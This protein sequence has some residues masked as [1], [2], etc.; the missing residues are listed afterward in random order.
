MADK[1]PARTYAPNK[2]YDQALKEAD[3][4]Y[5]ENNPEPPPSDT[6]PG[7]SEDDRQHKPT[8]R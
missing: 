1:L 6:N 4:H 2:K 8:N 7:T 3:P 5:K